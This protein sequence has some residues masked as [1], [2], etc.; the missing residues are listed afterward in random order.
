MSVYVAVCVANPF[1]TAVVLHPDSGYYYLRRGI[2]IVLIQAEKRNI[3]LSNRNESVL[4]C[5]RE[6]ALKYHRYKRVFGAWKP[7]E[8]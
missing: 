2:C 7:D 3:N 4:S 5:R 1:N 6:L 8:E